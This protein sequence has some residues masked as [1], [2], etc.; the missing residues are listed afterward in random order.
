MHLGV[1]STWVQ[2]SQ[3]GKA[4]GGPGSSKQLPRGSIG[5]AEKLGRKWW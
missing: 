4:E 3:G 2:G 5:W 1:P